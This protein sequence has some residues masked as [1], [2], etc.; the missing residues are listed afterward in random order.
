MSPDPARVA[1]DKDGAPSKMAW[2]R[3]NTATPSDNPE[4]VAGKREIYLLG[5]NV[6]GTGAKF[7]ISTQL[8]VPAGM[9]ARLTLL[10]LAGKASIVLAVAHALVDPQFPG[11]SVLVRGGVH[12]VARSHGVMNYHTI[13][14]CGVTLMTCPLWVAVNR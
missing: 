3:Q 4:S 8:G 6:S 7:S 14:F 2:A 12:L 1:P 10:I 9:R 11:L 13:S 5:W